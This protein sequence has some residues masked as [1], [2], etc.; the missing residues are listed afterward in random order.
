[1]SADHPQGRSKA[2]FFSASGFTDQNWIDLAEA[3]ER[4][5][6]EARL[7]KAVETQFGMTYVY[8]G[9]LKTPT[10]KRP[11]IRSVWFA[12]LS[13]SVLNFVTAFL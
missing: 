11:I 7:A 6:S 10:G 4:H 5:A 8:E 3:L 12:P 1:M 2:K 13:R 9:E